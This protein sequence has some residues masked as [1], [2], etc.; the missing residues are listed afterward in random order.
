MPIIDSWFGIAV[1][2]LIA[3]A[4]SSTVLKPDFTRVPQLLATST[5]QQH[6]FFVLVL[7]MPPLIEIASGGKSQSTVMLSKTFSVLLLGLSQHLRVPT[8]PLLP[9]PSASLRNYLVSFV[10]LSFTALATCYFLKL[11]GLQCGY[12]AH[13][14]VSLTNAFSVVFCVL[15]AYLLIFA[16]LLRKG[17][18]RQ[19]ANVA[20]VITLLCINTQ[21]FHLNPVITLASAASHGPHPIYAVH[22]A[23]IVAAVAAAR[24]VEGLKVSA[25]AQLKQ[26]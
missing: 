21:P 11:A 15:F 25:A 22:A 6:A 14:P 1:A 26:N 8:H 23:A 24:A 17:Y 20:L 2:S 19:W 5:F 16:D 18:S 4:A 7:S 3:F 9:P 10:P 12:A 13:S